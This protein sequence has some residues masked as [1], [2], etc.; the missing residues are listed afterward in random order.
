MRTGL[1]T[2]KRA[3]SPREGVARNVAARAD[4]GNG[5][6]TS[7]AAAQGGAAPGAAGAGAKPKF[8]PLR[9]YKRLEAGDSLTGKQLTRGA[10]ALTALETR[11]EVHGYS[12]LAKQLHNERETEAAGLGRLGS[13]LQSGVTDVY[14]NIATSEADSLARQQAMAGQLNTASAGIAQQGQQGLA[15]MQTG[16]LGDLTAGLEMRGAPGGGAAQQELANAVAQQQQAQSANSQAA[17]QFAAQQGSSYG[18]LGAMLAGSAQMQGGAAVSGIGQSIIGRVGASNQ[19]YDESIQSARQKLADAKALKGAKLV[20]NLLGLRGE[21]QKYEL[22]KAAVSSEKEKLAA[23]IAQDKASN[24]IAQQNADSSRISAE[25]SARNA[26]INAWE[27]HHPGASS[28][29]KATHRKE[30]THEVG[31]V[32]ALIPTVI[33]ELGRPP[34]DPKELN[35]FIGKLNSKASADPA[36]IRHVIKNWF[37]EHKKKKLR[38]NYPHR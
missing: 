13:T 33:A 20:K 15:A 17:Q 9:F 4:R 37:E 31:E 1:G 6:S 5:G 30:V 8:N 10:R 3:R 18:Q 7:G 36:L 34:Q 21:E 23:Q 26:A 11:P 16:Q 12:L 19:K 38:E 35:Q 29:E 24:A 28:N 22:G 14:K 2:H 32:K 25:A 27:A